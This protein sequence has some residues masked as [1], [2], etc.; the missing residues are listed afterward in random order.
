MNKKSVFI[1]RNDFPSIVYEL[2]K[3][4]FEIVIWPLS[5]KSVISKSKLIENVKGKFAIVCS[6]T[7]VI[8]K[9][10]IEAAGN[11]LKVVTT[12]SSGFEHLDIDELKSRGIRIGYSP[13][14]QLSDA[15]AEHAVGLLLATSRRIVEAQNVILKGEWTS[16][17]WSPTWM[18]GHELN[19]SSVAIVGCGRIGISVMKKVKSFDPKHIF[20]YNRSE[21]PEADALGG[22]LTSLD[23][24][25]KESDFIILALSLDEETRR[26]ISKERIN[27]MKPNAVIVNV[28]RGGLIDENALIE[29]LQSKKIGGAGLDVFSQEPLPTNSPL[30]KLDNVVATPHTAGN[31]MKCRIAMA[32]VGALNVLA[33]F[34][35]EEMPAEL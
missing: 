5:E 31:T 1:T 30:L 11:T 4:K 33:V 2:L 7:E 17:S 32:K 19:G 8:D 34:N 28:G 35:N 27:N 22:K 9:D 26:I 20:Y 23:F 21:K 18:C 29:A 13:V 10:V 24:I 6:R 25:M 14:D 15:V 3:Q 16:K 12:V